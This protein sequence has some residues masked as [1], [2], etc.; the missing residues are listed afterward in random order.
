MVIP[1]IPAPAAMGMTHLG[2][3]RPVSLFSSMAMPAQ[4][5]PAKSVAMSS[6]NMA[7]PS[8]PLPDPTEDCIVLTTT[9]ASRRWLRSK[10]D[11]CEGSR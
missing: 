3:R 9:K 6:T 8:A 5:T 1:I 4:P 11:S 10:S 7:Y 2:S